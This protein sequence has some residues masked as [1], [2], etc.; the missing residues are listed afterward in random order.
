MDFSGGDA[1]ISC[2]VYFYHSSNGQFQPMEVHLSDDSGATWVLADTISHLGEW[3]H[4]SYLVSQ[5][6]TPNANVRIRFKAND[7]PN[8][9][10]VE[11]LVDDISVVRINHNAT[12]WANAYEVSAAQGVDMNLYLGAGSGNGNRKYLVLG[13]FSGTVPGM[14]LPGGMNLAL[15][16]DLLTTVILNNLGTPAF[17]N[18]LGNLDAQGRTT[19]MMNSLGPMPAATIGMTMHFAYA[20]KGPWDYIS[21]S[22]PIEIDP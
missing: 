22:L 9:S 5:F 6:V 12:L 11:A 19:A 14:T 10:V 15:N 7:N 17:V 1:E 13:S 8:D 20:L 16:W 2:W 21:N 18:F 4:K 3:T